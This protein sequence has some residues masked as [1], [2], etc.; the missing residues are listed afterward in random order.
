MEELDFYYVDEWPERKRRNHLRQYHEA[1]RRHLYANGANKVHLSKNPTF[2]GRIESLIEEFPDARFVVLVR[3]P[4]EAI[5]SLL[6]LLQTAWKA[7]GWSEVR[8][9][10]A[11]DALARQSVHTYRYPLEVL[12]RHPATRHAIVDYRDLVA[13]PRKMVEEVYA[14]LGLEMTPSFAGVLQR[15]DEK[16]R[17][18]ETSYTYTLEEFGLDAT[19][20]RRDL[21]DL[22][23][24]F[25]WDP[26]GTHSTDEVTA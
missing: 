11:L 25:G 14:Q 21:A 20:I 24:R 7:A 23:E 5:P 10:A 22:F 4:L 12:G 8:F 18:H 26:E 16:A 17:R 3:N 19:Q 9:R 15:Q 13:H 6:H 2:S 1:V